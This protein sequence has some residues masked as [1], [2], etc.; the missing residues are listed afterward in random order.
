MAIYSTESVHISLLLVILLVNLFLVPITADVSAAGLA[1]AEVLSAERRMSDKWFG[2]LTTLTLYDDFSDPANVA[3]FEAVWDELKA[4]FTLYHEA[5]KLE[6]GSDVSRIN[7]LACGESIEIGLPAAAVLEQALHIYESTDGRFDPTVHVMV[8]L[9]GFTPRFR[10]NAYTPAM[11][12][13]RE[14]VDGRLP[15]PQPEMVEALLP[16]VG[17]DHFTIEMTESGARVTKCMP[18]VQID[19]VTVEAGMD[20]GGAAKGHVLNEG[21]AILRG[22]GYEYGMLSLGGSSVGVLQRPGDESD[23]RVNVGGLVDRLPS[24]THSSVSLMAK[25]TTISTSNDQLR[26]RVADDIIYAHIIDPFTGWPMH[27]YAGIGPDERAGIFSATVVGKDG[28]VGDGLATAFCLMK[29]AEAIEWINEI[30]ADFSVTLLAGKDGADR[31]EVIT[32]ERSMT[33]LDARYEIASE[34][35]SS[36]A[37]RYTGDLFQPE[38]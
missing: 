12:Y 33:I 24:A 14:L 23:Y 10:S 18:G 26:R 9:W 1:A 38:P 22:H 3:R 30:G 32:N 2:S 21:L 20:L 35:D 34:M 4:L 27:T 17:L 25:D 16:L 29:P 28:T 5:V 19:G 8:D 11:P 37:I 6:P 13:D 7:A 15:N 36:G 31:V